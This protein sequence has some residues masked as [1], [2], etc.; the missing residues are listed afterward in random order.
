MEVAEKD[1]GLR[2]SDDQDDEDEEEEAEHVVHLMGPAG[3]R[4][5]L[6]SVQT[7]KHITAWYRHCAAFVVSDH[8]LEAFPLWWV[9]YDMAQKSPASYQNLHLLSELNEKPG[10]FQ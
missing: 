4:R 9:H 7:S 10:H 2:A 8:C 3:Q 5:L 6:Q 1:G